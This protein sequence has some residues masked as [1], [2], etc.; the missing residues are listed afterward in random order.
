MRGAGPLRSEPVDDEDLLDE[1][2]DDLG[3]RMER[4]SYC[5]PVSGEP[6]KRDTASRQLKEQ[7][8]F[9]VSRSLTFKG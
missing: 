4:L 1:D 5:Q 2:D 6:F 8:R 3:R 7:G 9:L